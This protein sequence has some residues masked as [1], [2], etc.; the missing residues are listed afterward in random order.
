MEIR[1]LEKKD[2]PNVAGLI[3]KVMGPQ[4]RSVRAPVLTKDQ[5]EQA[6][7]EAMST[8]EFLMVAEEKGKLA[9]FL[10]FY[11]DDNQAFIEDLV[12]ESGFK[13]DDVGGALV[14]FMRD[15]CKKDGVNSMTMLVPF[16]SESAELARK[17][18]FKPTSVELRH[19]L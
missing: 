11:Y 2:I 3:V 15:L 13:K 9:G 14:N 4:F 18:N 6:L 5:Y 1:K 8:M 16:G 17:F 7:K 12:V 10:H 19:V